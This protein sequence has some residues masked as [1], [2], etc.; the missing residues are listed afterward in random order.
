[1][2]NKLLPITRMV[3]VISSSRFL[4]DSEPL[5]WTS[6][7]FGT[8]TRTANRNK[9]S[10]PWLFSAFETNYTATLR[11]CFFPTLSIGRNIRPSIKLVPRPRLLSIKFVPGW[12]KAR[13]TFLA[14]G[15]L[16][17]PAGAGNQ[18]SARMLRQVTLTTPTTGPL[19]AKL[20]RRQCKNESKLLNWNKIENQR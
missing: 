10:A 18:D 11:Q 15:Q 5:T 7:H 1:M 13:R 19:P 3:G 20:K 17:G 16:F 2:I 4:H 9:Y 8:R 12:Q 14:P 6:I